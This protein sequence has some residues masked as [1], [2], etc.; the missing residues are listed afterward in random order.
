MVEGKIGK[1]DSQI[2]EHFNQPDF[3]VYT[4]L[5]EMQDQGHIELI[6]IG[7]VSKHWACQV[8]QVFP[9]GLEFHRTGSYRRDEIK[10][11]WRE[12]PK[13]YW[14][15]GAIF[16]LLSTNAALVCN[17]VKKEKKD[18]ANTEVKEATRVDTLIPK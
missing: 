5:H 13:N 2:A 12:A 8:R 6:E 7:S 11:W 4:L 9:K 3:T 10:K 14:V 18:S 17:L 1:T 16:S 15:I